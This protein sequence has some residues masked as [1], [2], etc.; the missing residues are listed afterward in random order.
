M[1]KTVYLPIFKGQKTSESPVFKGLPH[2]Y[3]YNSLTCQKKRRMQPTTSKTWRMR[4]I[5]NSC[6]SNSV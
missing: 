5:S 4:D 2:I 3:I 6:S 1:Q